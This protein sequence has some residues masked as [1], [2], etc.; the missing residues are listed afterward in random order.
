MNRNERA[1]LS[2]VAKKRKAKREKMS[3]L[4]IEFLN[5]WKVL[6]IHPNIEPTH[7]F[8][9]HDKRKWRFD[10]AFPEA[11]VA[12]ELEGAV[13][14]RGRHTRGAGY[15]KDCEKYNAAQLLGWRVL[16]YTRGMLR[17]DPISVIAEVTM[18]L[19]P[20]T[21]ISIGGGK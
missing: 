21:D 12:V 2:A 20:F 1:L 19:M 4:E 3:D 8:R 14:S 6:S 13:Y 16:R 9:F 7:D 10:F 15:E 17:R 18:A 11:L 5:R